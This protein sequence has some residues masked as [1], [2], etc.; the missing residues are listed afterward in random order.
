M[1]DIGAGI[2]FIHTFYDDPKLGKTWIRLR[3]DRYGKEVYYLSEI[4]F[5]I[6]ESSLNIVT[7]TMQNPK[8]KTKVK[9]YRYRINGTT[10]GIYTL[11]SEYFPGV[12]FKSTSQWEALVRLKIELYN[13]IARI[14]TLKIN[15]PTKAIAEKIKHT[16]FNV[17]PNEFFHDT[18]GCRRGANDSSY[19]PFG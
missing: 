6:K 7:P 15:G 10:R 4:G 11:M 19:N 3:D 8:A 18:P 2:Q 1:I 17:I 12:K 9:F 5:C 13:D 14:C 16:K